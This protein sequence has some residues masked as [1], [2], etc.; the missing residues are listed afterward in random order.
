MSDDVIMI[1]NNIFVTQKRTLFPEFAYEEKKKERSVNVIVGMV[2][3]RT[4]RKLGCLTDFLK[5]HSCGETKKKKK[6]V[7]SLDQ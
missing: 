2:A 6:S 4:G 1:V 7:H 5:Q 3:Q